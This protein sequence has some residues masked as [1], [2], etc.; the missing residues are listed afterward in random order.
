[1][2]INKIL[3]REHICENIKKNLKHFEE[4]KNNLQTLRGIYIYG[5]CGMGKTHFVKELLNEMNYDIINYDSSNVRNKQFIE[6]I[7]KHKSSNINVLSMF[8]QKIKKLAIIMDEIDCMNTGDKG[9]IS[10]LIKMIRPKK[11][12]KQKTEDISNIPIICIGNNIIDKKLI[13]LSKVCNVYELK[14]P[15]IQQTKLLCIQLF[16]DM[17]IVNK[18]QQ[19]NLRQIFMFHRL[20]NKNKNIFNSDIINQYLNKKINYDNTKNTTKNLINNPTPFNKYSKAINETD[21]TTVALIL[22]ENIIDTIRNKNGI[23]IYKKILNTFCFSD[24][25]DRITFQKQIWQLNELSCILKIFYNLFTLHNSVYFTNINS[26]IRFTKILTKY[27]TEYNNYTFIQDLCQKMDLDKKD[28]ILF[29]KYLKHNE[30][31]KNEIL[32]HEEYDITT[33]DINRIYKFLNINL[34]D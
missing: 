24:Y 15:T 18:I 32:L 8:Q 34:T 30:D 17:N 6:N 2:N 9:G 31:L 13:E 10:A 29:F 1:M 12:K 3:N 22:H 7:T 26:D 5:N 27:S 11:T 20:Y 23:H 21:R 33:L 25:I 16:N 4:N 19:N 14:D 28:V